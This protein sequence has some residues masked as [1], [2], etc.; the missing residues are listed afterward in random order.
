MRQMRYYWRV[1]GMQPKLEG[2]IQNENNIQKREKGIENAKQK[3]RNIWDIVKRTKIHIA[4]VPEKAERH[5][6][7]N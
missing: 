6:S 7:T 2:N 4:W 1:N 3:L 5:Q